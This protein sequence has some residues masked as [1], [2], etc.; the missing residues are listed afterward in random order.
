M[1]ATADDFRRTV[2]AFASGVT[3]VT[4]ADAAGSPTGTTVTAFASLSLE[5]LL[6]MVS[7]NTDS[8][9]AAAIRERHA[10]VVHILASGQT[11]LARRFATD[12]AHKFAGVPYALNRH[13]APILK[14]CSTWLECALET[15]HLG[16]D[17]VILIGRVLEVRSEAEGGFDPVVYFQREFHTLGDEAP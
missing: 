3:I 12:Q 7:L 9:T 10:F 13:G 6:V 14:D 4:S 17:H 2:S 8:H 5:P 15:E 1:S 11:E 16:G